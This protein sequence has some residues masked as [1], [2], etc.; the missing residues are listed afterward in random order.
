MRPLW[1]FT[2]IRGEIATFQSEMYRIIVKSW[3]AGHLSFNVEVFRAIGSPRLML[4][5]SFSA[6][7]YR[8]MDARSTRPSPE[9]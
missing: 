3:H 7:S 1:L 2:W 5:G 4:P 8:D 9:F 6:A